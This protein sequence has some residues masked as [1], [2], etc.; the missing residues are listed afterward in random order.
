MRY[1]QKLGV[2]KQTDRQALTNALGKL[3]REDVLR[4]QQSS[5]A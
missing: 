4:L 1:L 3:K 5:E 2:S